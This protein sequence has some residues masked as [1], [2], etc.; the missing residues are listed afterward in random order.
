[1]QSRFTNSENL[2]HEFNEI[3]DRLETIVDEEQLENEFLDRESFS[4][5]FFLV[6]SKTKKILKEL[7]HDERS[8]SGSSVSQSHRESRSKKA[9]NVIFPPIEVPKF[10][11]DLRKLVRVS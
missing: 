3:Q 11:G 7:E 1:M 2:I 4:K 6:I 10:K 8:S 9:N 5:S